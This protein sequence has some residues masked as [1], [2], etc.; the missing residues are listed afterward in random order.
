MKA[1]TKAG[2]VTGGVVGVALGAS[3][4]MSPSGKQVRKAVN[5]GAHKL[6]NSI[7]HGHIG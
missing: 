4:L 2:F 1:A 6:K 3:I 5:W 7:W